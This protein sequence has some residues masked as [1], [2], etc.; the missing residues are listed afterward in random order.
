MKT[1]LNEELNKSWS[2]L[3]NLARTNIMLEDD[4]SNFRYQDY[5]VSDLHRILVQSRDVQES[6]ERKV[7]MFDTDYQMYDLR[8]LL[9]DYG[10]VLDSVST[11]D[12]EDNS[13]EQKND[14]ER[15]HKSSKE[16]CTA[17]SF[18]WHQVNEVYLQKYI[19]EI[20]SKTLLVE[21]EFQRGNASEEQVLKGLYKLNN[22]LQDLSS[23]IT[24]STQLLYKDAN[25]LL[26]HLIKVYSET[27]KVE[28]T[29]DRAKI[30]VGLTDVSM[31]KF[32][33]DNKTAEFYNFLLQKVEQDISE[34][35]ERIDLD[36]LCQQM[37]RIMNEFDQR[38]IDEDYIRPK[39]RN[40]IDTV[41]HAE[42]QNRRLQQKAKANQNNVNLAR[43]GSKN[44]AKNTMSTT[45]SIV[46]TESV[47]QLNT[48]RSQLESITELYS[49]ET[50][51]HSNRVAYILVMKTQL[52]TML[53]SLKS[54]QTKTNKQIPE[55]LKT[56]F[57][58]VTAIYQNAVSILFNKQKAE[59]V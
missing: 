55:E 50:T 51:V 13:Y 5:T 47:E 32:T 24:E 11:L 19:S 54:V 17:R 45:A 16:L 8:K 22:S 35:P 56:Q 26:S 30:E 40:L 2:I 20:I 14:Y 9:K 42:M 4:I 41:D 28:P 52:D 43:V 57:K 33:E 39:M 46:Y 31:D 49:R 21:E 10:Q 15:L 48:Y 23:S 36:D 12:V 18:N 6:Q 1:E 25:N 44:I 34:K 27:T 37:K 38:T 3:S 59:T 29:Q 7:K 53:N 58:D